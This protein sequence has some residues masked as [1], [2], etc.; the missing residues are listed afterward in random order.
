[1]GRPG[2]GGAVQLRP[3]RQLRPDRAS[4]GPLRTHRGSQPGHSGD[5]LRLQPQL[6]RAG[7][8][9]DRGPGGSAL[10][11]LFARRFQGHRALHR[12]AADAGAETERPVRRNAPKESMTTPIVCSLRVAAQPLKGQRLWPGKAGSTAFPACSPA[13]SGT[14]G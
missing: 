3:V 4:P 11:L 7:G 12:G 8:R 2:G 9:P 5:Q 13:A 1:M 14:A 6:R 10:G